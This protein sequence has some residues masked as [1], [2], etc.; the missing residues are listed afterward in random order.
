MKKKKKKMKKNFFIKKFLSKFGKININLIIDKTL[1]YLL[2][3]EINNNIFI[4]I[5]KEKNIK[6]LYNIFIANKI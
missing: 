4:E 2:T 5:F 1:T 3:N 6:N